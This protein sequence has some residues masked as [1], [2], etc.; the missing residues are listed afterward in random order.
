MWWDYLYPVYGPVPRICELW[1]YEYCVC[2]RLYVCV[3]V[4]C[5]FAHRLVSHWRSET[6]STSH[7][8]HISREFS[9]TDNWFACGRMPNASEI[10]QKDEQKEDEKKKNEKWNVYE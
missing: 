10:C 6:R 2:I 9:K 4:Y 7:Q 8:K 3:C 5:V 1:T